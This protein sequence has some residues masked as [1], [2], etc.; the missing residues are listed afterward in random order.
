MI[1]LFISLLL[2]LF[3][4]SHL[5]W[6]SNFLSAWSSYI[7]LFHSSSTWQSSTYKAFSGEW[8]LDSLTGRAMPLFKREI[9]WIY[10][11]GI[12]KIFLRYLSPRG[13]IIYNDCMDNPF[14]RYDLYGHI[15]ARQHQSLGSLNL[16]YIGRSFLT[17]YKVCLIYE[18][19]SLNYASILIFFF[20]T[21]II[22]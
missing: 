7:L 3:P 22:Y 5:Y 14:S 12:E 16:Q 9:K 2:D 4:V 15:L 11:D 21:I 19:D 1:G 17:L 20:S 8:Y 10:I 13:H 6:S 18:V